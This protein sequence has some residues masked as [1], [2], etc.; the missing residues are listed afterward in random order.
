MVR[1]AYQPTQK[2]G[3]S[4]ATAPLVRHSGECRNPGVLVHRMNSQP[5]DTGIRRYDGLPDLMF[6]AHE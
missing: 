2:K 3:M 1:P 4:I 6:S 5:L